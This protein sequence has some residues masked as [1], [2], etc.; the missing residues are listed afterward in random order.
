[1][2][3]VSPPYE[4]SYQTRP[5]VRESTILLPYFPPIPSHIITTASTL[6]NYE[7]DWMES[8][9]PNSYLSTYDAPHLA[10]IGKRFG[11]SIATASSRGFCVLD[12]SNDVWTTIVN[13]VP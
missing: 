2:A 10:T 8:R 4:A 5:T 9:I 1:M 13:P 6:K 12:R 7:I 11:R 3:I